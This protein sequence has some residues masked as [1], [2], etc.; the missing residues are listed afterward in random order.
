MSENKLIE[1]LRKKKEK[2]ILNSEKNI[3]K[4]LKSIND[5]KADIL[6]KETEINKLQRENEELDKKYFVVKEVI[7]KNGL[8]FSIVNKNYNVKEWD[9]LYIKTRED[10]LVVTLKDG[11]EIKTIESFKSK[12]LKGFLKGHPYSI[13]VTRIESNLIKAKL[14]FSK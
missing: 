2:S 14:Y 10:F 6:K 1:H 4:Y 12:S 9:N 11:T 8:I 5:L 13:V 3:E 7:L